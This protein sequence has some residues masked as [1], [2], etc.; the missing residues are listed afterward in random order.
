MT[1]H[2]RALS[3]ALAIGVFAACDD[4]P[5]GP[6]SVAVVQVAAPADSVVVGGT[7]SLSATLQDRRGTELTGREVEWASDNPG[8][9][10]VDGAGVVTAV[11]PGSATIT[12]SS[13]KQTGRFT[14][15]VVPRRAATVS[16]G[17]T[18]LNLVPQQAVQLNLDAR[19]AAGNPVTGS[20]VRW[21]TDDSTFVTISSTGLIRALRPGRGAVSA[22]VD[23]AVAVVHVLAYTERLHVWPDTV[24]LLP[25]GTH[26]LAA[27]ARPAGAEAAVLDRVV[28]ESSNPAVARVDSL[29]NVTA[30]ASGR[31]TITAVAGPSRMSSEAYVS[32]YPGALRFVSVAAGY[33]H[34][35]GVTAGGDAY[36]WG[37]GEFAQL[38][39]AQPTTRCEV[40][41]RDTRTVID[42]STHRCSSI[43][44]PVAGG[45]KF[46]S[47]SSGDNRICG[48][49][50]EGA[51]YCWGGNFV[52]R[53]DSGPAPAPSLPPTRVAGNVVFR[54]IS[55][56]RSMTCG[57]STADAAYCW[58]NAVSGSLGDGTSNSSEVPVAVAGGLSF[59]SVSTGAMHACGVTTGGDAYCW[60][61]SLNNELGA[62]A[63]EVCAPNNAPC[64]K[65]PLKVSGGLRFRSIE[66]GPDGTCA[67]DTT[68]RAYC[69]GTAVNGKLGNGTLGGTSVTPVAVLGSDLTFTTLSRENAVCGLLTDG[70]PFCWGQGVIQ[71]NGTET[72]QNP[73]PVR[74]APNMPLRS[75]SIGLTASCGIATDGITYCWGRSTSG[76]LGNGT[77]STAMVSSARVLGQ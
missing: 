68:G 13:E 12:A 35:C 61:A 64:A 19:D 65:T 51:V 24:G 30:V 18:T 14:V 57:V 33:T 7:L 55:A 5:S 63:P 4:D 15:R 3:L 9:A 48:L 32:S 75:L 69:W 74:S 60:G 23:G 46:T 47:I 43:P 17:K 6:A 11:A 36:C 27:R 2:L 50:A 37:S 77:Y 16:L 22:T 39:S 73:V 45:V 56:G 70:S 71:P 40:F 8:V 31:A 1:R 28:W 41:Y 67:L 58:G 54:S 59:A 29:G 21:A 26:T 25:G 76:Q 44:V 20:P 52:P 10:R 62:P 53:Y 38:V 66:A 34:A 42:R 72:L 49:T